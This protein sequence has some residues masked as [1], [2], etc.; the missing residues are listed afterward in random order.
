[1][2]GVP[3]SRRTGAANRIAGWKRCEKQNPIPTSRTQRPTPSGPRSIT[4][5]SASS[6]STEPH[7]DDAARPPCLAT[8]TPAAATTMAAMVDTLTVPAPSPPVPQVSTTGPSRSERSTCSANRSIV[9]TSVASSAASRPWHGDPTANAA[10][11]ASVASPA[12]IVDIACSTRSSGRS[13]R[14]SRRP[15]TSGHSAAFISRMLPAAV[16]ATPAPKTRNGTA[17]AVLRRWRTSRRRSR[18]SRPPQTPCFSRALS[19]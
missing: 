5:P 2:V 16:R 12:R 9:R 14:R 17:Q 18:S 19:A 15:M 1:M 4:T 7:L 13:S 8:R 10:I 11:W 3:S 6:T